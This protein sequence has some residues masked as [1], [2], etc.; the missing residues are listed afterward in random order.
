[1]GK[2]RFVEFALRLTLG[3][4]LRSVLNLQ[5]LFSGSPKLRLR[6]ECP[7][8]KD[9]LATVPPDAEPGDTVTL[10]LPK[11]RAHTPN[12]ENAAFICILIS[13]PVRNTSPGL[14][15]RQC[16]RHLEFKTRET[17]R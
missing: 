1:M 7:L 10:Q 15:Q 4:N 3:R 17:C 2:P 5:L 9:V 6:R 16:S 11:V 13:R 8:N 12:R 14:K